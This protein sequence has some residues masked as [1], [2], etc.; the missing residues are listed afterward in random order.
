MFFILLSGK[1]D[2]D[3]A[4]ERDKDFGNMCVKYGP[5]F[6][7]KFGQQWAVFIEDTEDILKM[8]RNEGKYP[9][10]GEALSVEFPY[11][12]GKIRRFLLEHCGYF[13]L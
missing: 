12:K 10:R 6:Q 1:R 4:R 11:C 7:E 3:F 2:K 9:Y 5:I 13:F 8:Y